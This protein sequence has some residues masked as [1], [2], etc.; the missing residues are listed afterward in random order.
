LSLQRELRCRVCSAESC[1]E[2]VRESTVRV[3]A[4]GITRKKTD[5]A[6]KMTGYNFVTFAVAQCAPFVA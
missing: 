1:A 3:I 5:I 2:T 4:K 6:Q